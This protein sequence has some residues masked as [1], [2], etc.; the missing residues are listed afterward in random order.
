[1]KPGRI[2]FQTLCMLAM[3]VNLS[4]CLISKAKV[5]SD[6]PSIS[7][8]QVI[9]NLNWT[10][11]TSSNYNYDTN[12][13]SVTA[14]KATLATVDQVHNSTSDFAKGTHT[15]TEFNGSSLTLDSTTS[16]D[17]SFSSTWTP[18]YSRL[19]GYWKMDNNWNDSIGSAHGTPVGNSTFSTYRKVGSHSGTFD[20][21]DDYIN[22][23]DVHNI[24]ASD[25]AMSAWVKLSG[26]QLD[27]NLGTRFSVIFGKGILNALNGGAGIALVNE[28]PALQIR[29][30]GNIY[31]CTSTQDLNDNI[32]HHLVA[33][34]DRDDLGTLYI[35]GVET[36]SI[37]IS[38]LNNTSI[39]TNIDMGIGSGGFIDPERFDFDYFGQIDEVAIWDIALTAADVNFI[40]EK[41]SHKY[42]GIYTSNIIN[43]GLSDSWTDLSWTTPLPFG[44]EL[45]GSAGDELVSDY[46][47]LNNLSGANGDSDLS[48]GLVGLWHFNEN[49]W[50]QVA[51]EVK[52]SSSVGN[53]GVSSPGDSIYSNCLFRNCGIFNDTDPNGV[54]I[55]PAGSLALDATADFSFS[56]WMNPDLTYDNPGTNYTHVLNITGTTGYLLALWLMDAPSGFDG[57]LRMV[58]YNGASAVGIA[59][60]QGT[61]HGKSFQHILGLKSGNTLS[62]YID[63]KLINSVVDVD[64]TGIT[65][66]NVIMG[67]NYYTGLI[68]EVAIW[69]RALHE[70]EIMELYH[71][72]AN[73]VK[74]QVRSCDDS[75]CAGEGWIGPD[76]TDQTY[77]SELHNCSSINGATGECNGT[78][79]LTSPI[80]TFADFVTAPIDNQYFQYKAILTSDDENSLCSGSACMPEI[81]S[82]QIGPTGRYF[83]GSPAITNVTPVP[84][85]SLSAVTST[86]SGSCIPTYQLSLDNSNFY[87]WNGANWVLAPGVVQ[88]NTIVDLNANVSTFAVDVGIG[89]IYWKVFLNSDTTNDCELDSLLFSI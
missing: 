35:D 3:L 52:D 64:F 43:L 4:S 56:L 36:C 16:A 49:A 40:Y 66:N 9:L 87:Y 86:I 63:G 6:V 82:I 50:A 10:F 79:G 46:S 84:F 39:I 22:L 1:M 76:G 88:S 31:T 68:D 42:A 18:K 45:P 21:T 15:G 5:K 59:S 29:L 47:S 48:S 70:H 14:G 7:L 81:S 83:G 20:G 30:A 85:T 32:W 27:T 26:L 61:I 55:V 89:E 57:Q 71:R 75:A 65:A 24:G 73:K 12:Y 2:S 51:A 19:K 34:F 80:L 78:I 72:G 77:F 54:V 13:I 17:S 8:A 69:N 23:G 67:D 25:Q 62:F 60:P 37:D 44:K 11:S 28:M 38:P 53:D 58:R 41:Q 33:V 74:Y